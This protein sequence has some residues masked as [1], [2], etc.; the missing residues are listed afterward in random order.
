MNNEAIKNDLINK[1]NLQNE[2]IKKLSNLYNEYKTKC[3]DL[4][5]KYENMNIKN[6]KEDNFE[7]DFISNNRVNIPKNNQNNI[8]QENK[9]NINNV[10]NYYNKNYDRKES[11]SLNYSN[12]NLNK[13]CN[14]YDFNFVNQDKYKIE[15]KRANIYEPIICPLIQID[16]ELNYYPNDAYLICLNPNP[17]SFKNVKYIDSISKIIGDKQIQEFKIQL[18]FDK[19]IKC[20]VYDVRVGIYSKSEGRLTNKE[21]TIKITIKE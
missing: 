7:S 16:F 1:I 8:I 11:S 19:E 13:I 17:I 9:N 6:D 21:A 20:G 14:K 2:E 15:I 10:N 5:N 18:I 4:K 12:I 3:K